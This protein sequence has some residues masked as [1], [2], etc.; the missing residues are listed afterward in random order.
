MEPVSRRTFLGSVSVLGVAGVAGATGVAALTDG[1]T[2]EPEL[3]PEEL[4]QLTVPVVLQVQDASK[5]EVELLVKDKSIVF[6]D[7]ALVAKLLRA[8]G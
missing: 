5:G 3:R 8:V 7:R 4:E 1:G 6:T 2:E